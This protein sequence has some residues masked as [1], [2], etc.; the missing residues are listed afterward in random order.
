SRRRGVAEGEGVQNP[1]AEHDRH[2]GDED[3]DAGDAHR[4]PARAGQRAEQ[5]AED[6]PVGVARDGPEDDEA[7]D[8]PGE[9]GA[10]DA[11][12]YRATGGDA[13]EGAGEQEGRGEGDQGAE[14]RRRRQQERAAEE[15]HG[16]GAERGAGGE[17]E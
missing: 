16:Y 1:A 8:R 12:Q 15:E 14:E 6:L 7:R 2:A 4:R 13:P 5:P 11:G 3:G 10:G 9:G 17:P